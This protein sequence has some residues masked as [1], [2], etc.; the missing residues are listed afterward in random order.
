[1][2]I[3]L[4]LKSIIELLK[5]DK[6]WIPNTDNSSLYIRPLIFALDP[7]IGIKSADMYKFIIITALN[8]YLNRFFIK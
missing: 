8:L 4:F 2:L 5:I 3:Y 7:F 6:K 1:M